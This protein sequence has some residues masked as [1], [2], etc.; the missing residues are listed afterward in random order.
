MTRASDPPLFVGGL[1]K[2]SCY[3]S[4][5]LRFIWIHNGMVLATLP[6]A[7]ALKKSFRQFGTDRDTRA[8]VMMAQIRYTKGL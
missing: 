1:I 7:D 3:S 8:R 5:F 4:S 6:Q 2:L